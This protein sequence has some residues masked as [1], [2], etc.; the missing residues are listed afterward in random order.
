MN[1]RRDER[2]FVD[3]AVMALVAVVGPALICLT[4]ALHGCPPVQRVHAP[5]PAPVA[6]VEREISRAARREGIPVA[7]VRSIAVAE[8]S[9][10]STAVS[11]TGA[12]GIMQLEPA[13]AGDCGVSNRYDPH[14]NVMC[15]TRLLRSLLRRYAGDVRRVIAAFNFGPAAVDDARSH[16]R[17]MPPETTQYVA[18][19]L[20]MIRAQGGQT[21]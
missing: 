13:A 18:R 1:R 21:E 5:V 8:S 10:D 3:A 20:A 7:L 17:P 6:V 16:H 12:V 11:P 9:L 15:G 4:H 2:G 14:Q 19:V